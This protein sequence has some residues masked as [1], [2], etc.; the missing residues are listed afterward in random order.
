MKDLLLLVKI[1]RPRFW[2]YILGPYLIGLAA[3]SNVPADLLRLKVLIWAIYFTLPA[4]LL[5]YGINDIFDHETDR[6]NPKK[7]H[8]ESL[9][10]PEFYKRLYIFIGILNVPFLIFLFIFGSQN[11]ILSFFGF[12]F[13]SVFYSAPPIRAKVKPVIDSAFNI[14][15]V[16]P[17]IFSFA[18]LTGNFPA[19]MT[20][21]AAGFWTMAM[22]AYSAIPDIDSDKKADI[23]TIA[24]WLG[25]RGSHI[26]CI[27]C[28]LAATAFSFPFVGYASIVF[29]IAYLAMMIVSLMM[30]N[31]ARLFDVYR[32]FPLMNTIIG[33]ALF[34]IVAYSKFIKWS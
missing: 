34:W 21:I 8:F 6:L 19:G 27:I 7:R 2:I 4:N 24:T 9:L 26:F 14:L 10:A 1:S 20:I 18:L 30:S 15:Y 28:Y 29:G 11:A 31:S 22:H 23:S 16:F 5:I 12:L 25:R 32:K 33:F 3:A 17:G 13:F